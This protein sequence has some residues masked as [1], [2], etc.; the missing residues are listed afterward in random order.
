MTKIK[1]K[2][3]NLTFKRSNKRVKAHSQVLNASKNYMFH[4]ML[5]ALVCFMRGSAAAID[6]AFVCTKRV[7]A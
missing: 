5:S 1:I 7:S 2:I 3:R 6:A 4:A